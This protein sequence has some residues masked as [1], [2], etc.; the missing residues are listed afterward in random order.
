[1]KKKMTMIMFA[2]L[3]MSA[4]SLQAGIRIGAKAGVNLAK[5]AF[6]TDAL[7][8]DNFTGFQVGPIIEISGFSGFSGLGI[9]AAVLYSQQGV[10]FSSYENKVSA[11]DI[12]VNLKMKFS[13]L[14]L[15]GMYISAGP[16]LSF[17]L[18]DQENDPE[19]LSQIK[20]LTNKKSGAGLNF[21]AGVELVKHLQVG[22]NYQFALNGDYN[23]NFS[24]GDYLGNL[25]PAGNAK[26]R[27]WSITAAYFF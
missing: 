15:L 21:G 10:K 17:K 2:I 14:D 27:I 24:L 1:M 11:L 26:T 25:T 4:F 22:V 8:S 16:Y 20:G 23:S 7:K 5:A 6:N 19:S 9:D 12:P 13:L 3:W 18:N